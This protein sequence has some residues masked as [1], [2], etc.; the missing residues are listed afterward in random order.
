MIKITKEKDDFTGLR[1]IEISQIPFLES[2]VKKSTLFTQKE[3]D[4]LGV[5]NVK[6][7]FSLKYLEHENGQGLISISILSLID[8]L[9]G[10]KQWPH[11]NDNWPMIIDGERINLSSNLSNTFESRFELKVYSLPVDI[12]SKLC[13]ATE[14]KYSLRGKY[15]KIEESFTE[16]HL[17]V[18]KAFEHYCFG[19]ENEGKMIIESVG[20][21]FNK[22][23]GKDES[24]NDEETTN[25]SCYSC[26]SA[27]KVPNSWE[28]FTC[29][30]CKKSNTIIRPKNL[31]DDDRKKHENKVV[32]L[33][34]EN[35]IADAIKYYAS[36]FG[37][38][39]DVSSIKVKELAEKNG[40]AS[41][42]RK[43]ETKK[44]IIVLVV[45]AVIIFVI[46]KACS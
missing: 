45:L 33:I 26:K 27:N 28:T 19:D 2:S 30:Y 13:K 3:L 21:Y 40:L 46:F 8:Q 12:F 17:K 37:Y 38:L 41:A 32:E 20:D 16:N 36:N 11:W 42:Y 24:Q 23:K 1:K 6:D 15:E 14:I 18:F 5:Y 39:E 29:F 25:Y 9:Y 34:K 44:T 43:Y 35:K 10:H 31:T 22:F 4:A 7:S